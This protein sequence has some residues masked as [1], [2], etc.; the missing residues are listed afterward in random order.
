MENGTWKC[1]FCQRTFRY[2]RPH[3]KEWPPADVKAEVCL[4]SPGWFFQKIRNRSSE[5]AKI[6]NGPAPVQG[7]LSPG[8]PG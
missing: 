2:E 6:Q 3:L 5:N 7:E 8:R 1:N 4:G